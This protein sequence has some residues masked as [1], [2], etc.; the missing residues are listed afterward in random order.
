MILRFQMDTSERNAI[1]S[2][3]QVAKTISSLQLRYQTLSTKVD[4]I[5]QMGQT[6]RYR[7]SSPPRISRSLLLVDVVSSLSDNV[8]A[9]SITRV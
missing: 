8:R 3:G 7:P 6:E 4:I 2:A 9:H 1:S 5:K